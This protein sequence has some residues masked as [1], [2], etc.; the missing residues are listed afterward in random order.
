M[1]TQEVMEAIYIHHVKDR[2]E[3]STPTLAALVVCVCVCVCDKAV[4]VSS[5]QVFT[6]EG[7]CQLPISKFPISNLEI[8]T[9]IFQFQY[10]SLLN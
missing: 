6:V 4:T 10:F 5:T 2:Q 9:S 1:L 7:P 8:P 3:E